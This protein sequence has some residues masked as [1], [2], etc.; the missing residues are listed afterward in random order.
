MRQ[1]GGIT[2]VTR[3]GNVYSKICLK[4]KKLHPVEFKDARDVCTPL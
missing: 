1:D 2:I 4:A 3:L